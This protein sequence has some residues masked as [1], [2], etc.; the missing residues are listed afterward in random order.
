MSHSFRILVHV[1]VNRVYGTHTVRFRTFLKTFMFKFRVNKWF[2]LALQKF[3][4][5][6]E[7]GRKNGGSVVVETT[8]FGFFTLF[9]VYRM[10]LCE[11]F[12][13]KLHWKSFRKYFYSWT[14]LFL[15]FTIHI[16][17]ICLLL[18]EKTWIYAKN[19]VD[20]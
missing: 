19:D 8:V 12:N 4:M 2:L 3:R 10:L 6:D 17:F 11:K 5:F 16:V 18:L 14:L 15:S 20:L 7:F 9:S 1:V 13:C